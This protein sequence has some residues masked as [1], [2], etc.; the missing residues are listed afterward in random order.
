MD[1][2]SSWPAA[3][4]RVGT[5][6]VKRSLELR[7]RRLPGLARPVLSLLNT[8]VEHII[9]RMLHLSICRLLSSYFWWINPRRGTGGSGQSTRDKLIFR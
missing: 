2:S 4:W 3:V 5:V 7:L 8:T 1:P 6:W 9:S